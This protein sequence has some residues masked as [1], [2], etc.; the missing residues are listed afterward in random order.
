M[1]VPMIGRSSEPVQENVPEGV[2]FYS[3]LIPAS[4]DLISELSYVHGRTLSHRVG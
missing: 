3:G 2:Q 1:D 4:S